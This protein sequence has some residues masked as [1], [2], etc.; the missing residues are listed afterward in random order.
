MGNHKRL[1]EAIIIVL[2]TLAVGVTVT[3][4]LTTLAH[5]GS[6]YSISGQNESMEEFYDRYSRL[7]DVYTL[8]MQQYYKELDSDALLEG[9]INGMTATLNDPYTVYST[10]AQMESQESARSGSYV[11]LGVE[12]SASSA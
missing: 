12:V 11:G 6:R 3:S 7:H 9:A 2:L 1:A 8:I 10:P 5:G 4:S